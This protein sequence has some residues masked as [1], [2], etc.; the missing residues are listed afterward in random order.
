MS[1]IFITLCLLFFLWS[2][3]MSQTIH[4]GASSLLPDDPTTHYSR[5]VNFAPGDG[6]IVD[7]NPPRFRWRYHP[8]QPGE[9]GNYTFSFQIA[10]DAHFQNLIHNIDT[11]FNFYNTLASFD[12]AGPYYWRIGYK[13]ENADT[14]VH[15]SDSRTFTISPDA[16]VWDRASMAYP[17][18][19]NV[20]HPRLLF[21]QETLPKLREIT[22][23]NED[24]KNIFARMQREA[25]EIVQS[26]W[27]QNGLP[28]TDHEPAPEKYYHIA[29][30]LV[31][32]AFVYTLTQDEKY[33]RVK[34]HALTF[35]RYPKGGLASP[36]G[37][38]GEKDANE[39]ATQATEFLA[40]LYDWLYPKLTEQERADFVHSLDWRIESFV[41]DFA[42][43]RNHNGT[44]PAYVHGSSLSVIGASHAFEGFFD[45]FPAA[46][47]IYEHSQNA[48]EAF[49]LGI[50]FMAG[51]GSAHGFSE[52]WNEGPGYG[53]S[54][55]AWQVNAMSYLDSLFPE[56]GV[57]Q[58]PWITRTG[59]F[60]RLQTPVGIQRAPWGHGS[61]NTRYYES[62]HRRAYRKLAFLTND[63]RFLANW[64]A[65]GW[66]TTGSMDRPWIECTLPLWR[67]KPTPI[68]EENHVRAFPR[69][70]WVMAMSG[71]PN[72]P[73]TYQ[74]GLGIIFAA[75]PRGG[76]SHSLA[77][78]NSFH[79]FGYG[80]DLSHA[81]GATP[82]GDAC[83][84]HSMSHNTIL[85]DGLGQFQ[86]RSA[87][88]APVIARLIA[89]QQ[90]DTVTYWCGDATL[91][92]PRTPGEVKHWWGGLDD[93]YKTRDV[94]HLTR[95]N[96]HVLFVRN[97]YFVMLDDLEATKPTQFTWLYHIQPE[98]PFNLNAHSGSFTYQLDSVKV[99][100]V[101]LLG[102]GQLDIHDMQGADGLKNPLTGED[103]TSDWKK[104]E[105]DKPFTV[106]HSLFLTNKKPQTHWRFL[107]VILPAPLGTSTQPKIE[108]LDDLTIKV[109]AFGQT[110]IISFDPNNK[111]NATIAIDL[112]T[113]AKTGLHK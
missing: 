5:A 72:D 110:D 85:V 40:L 108:R 55:W 49:H 83:S 75:R 45:T 102:T 22:Q 93:I 1:R 105:G 89:F 31:Q 82:Y 53:N 23:T 41:Y 70:G 84:Y 32:V 74:N 51:V 14:I 112:P 88:S 20:G 39:D 65:Y 44:R 100:V 25:D 76:Y 36:E 68:V 61:N 86:G 43:K 29:G 50:N 35:A 10:T 27:W 92:Y 59:A 104:R 98:G 99:D 103:Y 24:S 66:T 90:S 94:S 87:Q 42:W 16:Q 81:G 26:T 13:E 77:C 79:I 62:G 54:K 52:G 73:N 106:A 91:A 3:A 12:G 18:F 107:S 57:G 58:N 2:N 6:E 63:G 111:H 101:H 30:K 71:P 15:W 28:T 80:H 96:R 17:D 38:G 69:S 8:T 109:T 60:M 19:S 78:D 33:N 48:R 4:I 11:P 56:Y 64:Q 47:A 34:E 113:I 9:G 7:L 21:T 95:F 37:A 67:E 46:L 97:K